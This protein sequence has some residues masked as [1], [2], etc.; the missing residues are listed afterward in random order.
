M[1]IRKIMPHGNSL[2]VGIPSGVCKDLNL[3]RGDFLVGEIDEFGNIVLAKVSPKVVA[4]HLE[5]NQEE[6]QK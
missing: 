4:E 2:T 1:F 5:V 6:T 3:R